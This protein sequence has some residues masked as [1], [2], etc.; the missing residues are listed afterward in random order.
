[1]PTPTRLTCTPD[2]RLLNPDFEGYQVSFDASAGSVTTYP[3]PSPGFA[4]MTLPRDVVVSYGEV[5]ARAT[6]NH[7]S[8]SPD[9]TRHLF[10][11]AAHSVWQVQSDADGVSSA[12]FMFMKRWILSAIYSSQLIIK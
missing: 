3:I 11:D 8:S 4:I 10:I 2:R 7:L 9:G 12:L 6:F 1:M 5:H